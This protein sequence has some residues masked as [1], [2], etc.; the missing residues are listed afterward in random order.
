MASITF[1]KPNFDLD[2]V[3]GAARDATYV[4]IG[5]AVLAFQKVQTSRRDLTKSVTAQFGSSKAQIDEVVD[6]LEAR[7]A[8]L[9]AKLVEIESKLDVAVVDLEKRLPER[10][11]S[12]LGSAHEAAKSARKQ[13]RGLLVTAA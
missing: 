9:D 2:A 8:S 11:A 6:A 10:A 1:P 4:T 7:L 13:V 12:L 3:T 5:L